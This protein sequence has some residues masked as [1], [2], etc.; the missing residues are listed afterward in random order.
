MSE[1]QSRTPHLTQVDAPAGVALPTVVLAREVVPAALVAAVRVGE[2]ERIRSGAY[3]RATPKRT[4]RAT[5]SAPVAASKLSSSAAAT[6]LA[7]ARIAAVGRQ[8]RTPFWFSHESAALIWGCAVWNPPTR[9]HLIQTVRPNRHSDPQLAR[10][11]MG[12]A[13]ADRTTRRGVPVTSLD[14]TV[15]DCLTALPP[16]DALVIADSALRLGADPSAI[17]DRVAAQAGRRGVAAARVVLG[18]ADGQAESPWETFVRYVLLR[19]GLPRPELQIP[20]RTRLG[21]FRADLGWSEWKLLIEFDGF[22]KYSTLSGGDPARAV[23]EEK[24][25][26]DA[27]EE[28]GWGVLRVTAADRRAPE[29]L[30]QRVF[31][32]LPSQIVTNLTPI[33]DLP[34]VGGSSSSC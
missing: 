11:L 23:F 29:S 5:S 10:H 30:L 12:L 6:E 9:T 27:I 24:R 18:F 32:R 2:L 1:P 7:L 25:R 14:R 33:R 13:P 22:V 26:Q 17:A 31:R 19:A 28:E 4:G 34:P 16:L 8:L 20:V 21:W 15:A 3:R